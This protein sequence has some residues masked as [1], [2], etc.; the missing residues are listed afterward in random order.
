MSLGST[1]QG[2]SPFYDFVFAEARK[3]GVLVVV[4]SGND[5]AE[6][7]APANS[8]DCLS[9]SSTSRYQVGD[10]LWEWLSGFSNR[11]ERIDVAAPGGQIYSTVP[12]Y[13]N[14]TGTTSYA[15]MSGTSMACPYVAGLAALLVAKHDPAN[16]RQD[17]AFHD[18]VRQHI[19]ATS[20]DLGALGRDDKYG[21]GR[22]NVR[23]AVTSPFP[24]QVL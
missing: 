17:A 11:G 22:V 20:D 1:Y 10:I 8:P 3:R 4:A 23:R 15:T 7:C 13:A 2:R 18:Q 16:T 5:G 14:S 9:V 12:T 19:M 21:H 6:V 24:A